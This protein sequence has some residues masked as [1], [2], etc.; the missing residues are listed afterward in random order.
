MKCVRIPPDRPPVVPPMPA[1]LRPAALVL[2]IWTL[3][4]VFSGAQW[5]LFQVSRGVSPDWGDALLPNLASCWM[6]AG[7]TPAIVRLAA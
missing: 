6:W 3:V 7:F 1:A 4:A 2:G 5:Y